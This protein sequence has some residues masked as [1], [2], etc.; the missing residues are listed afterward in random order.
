MAALRNLFSKIWRLI[1]GMSDPFPPFPVLESESIRVES[2][3]KH[4][5]SDLKKFLLVES[6]L[7]RTDGGLHWRITFYFKRDKHNN[8]YY[9]FAADRT[10]SSRGEP[11]TARPSLS[12]Q[13]SDSSLQ[14]LSA[15]QPK[16]VLD[17]VRGFSPQGGPSK[18]WW[19]GGA[20]NDVSITKL[21]VMPNG[22]PC[23][24]LLDVAI[25]LRSVSLHRPHYVLAQGNCWWFARC[26]GLLLELLAAA[27]QTPEA[28]E[29]LEK[30]FFRRAPIAPRMIGDER[31]RQ[32]I[33]D[34][35]LSFERL[36]R[37]QSFPC[38]T[39]YLPPFY[40]EYQMVEKAEE[41]ENRRR[42]F[43]RRV[44]EE[45]ECR[46]RVWQERAQ[47]AEQELVELRRQLRATTSH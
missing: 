24:T 41:E 23:L 28:R 38:Q 14:L 12:R 5:S 1:V 33:A 29:A 10:Q 8:T 40:P 7:S 26:S 45:A 18:D 20:P 11:S 17:S 43:E 32:D 46:G 47:A 39:F 9:Y 15:Y 42:E 25:V 44:Q 30:E 4:D 19:K 6:F 22:Q 16:D 37:E 31:V 3:T 35:W 27:P 36:V 13:S 2:L 34:I 21:E